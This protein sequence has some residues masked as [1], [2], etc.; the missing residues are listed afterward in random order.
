MIKFKLA[1]SVVA[2]IATS[3]SHSAEKSV[4]DILEGQNR[5]HVPQSRYLLAYGKV[6][7]KKTAAGYTL[8]EHRNGVVVS[9]KTP[10]GAIGT[11]MYDYQGRLDEIQYTDGKRVKVAYS[12]DGKVKEVLSVGTKKAARFAKDAPAFPQGKEKV[13]NFLF[14]QAGMEAMDDN[15]FCD[16]GSLE[17]DCVINISGRRGG[18]GG[19]DPGYGGSDPG[20]GPGGG[21][22]RSGGGGGGGYKPVVIYPQTGT[23]Y[24]TPALCK[25]MVCEGGKSDHEAAC[26]IMTG[27]RPDE[28]RRCYDKVFEYYSNCLR[29]CGNADWSWLDTFN[30]VY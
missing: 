1:F 7:A 9:E 17:S 2:L 10:T 3:L 25:D 19:I 23:V 20:P 30:W 26:V 11:Y 5:A 18:G 14:V 21:R 4:N 22:E 8:F 15:E 16:T 13:G 6:L 24:E 28:L 12:N 29:S 27:G